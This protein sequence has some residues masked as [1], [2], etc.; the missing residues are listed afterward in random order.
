MRFSDS[1]LCM[2]LLALAPVQAALLSGGG[3]FSPLGEAQECLL[4]PSE[5]CPYPD[6]GPSGLEQA[7][8]GN[9]YSEL[10]LS[11]RQG[12][13]WEWPGGE[14]RTGRADMDFR[15]LVSAPLRSAAGL[16]LYS[17]WPA[18]EWTRGPDS[19]RMY[20][21]QPST[22][23]SV[24]LDWDLLSMHRESSQQ[25][26]LQAEL[27]IAYGPGLWRVGAEYLP[28]SNWRLRG[29]YAQ[30]SPREE[31][32]HW[33]GEETL[34]EGG[35]ADIEALTTQCR[36]RDCSHQ[37]EPGCAVRAAIERGEID[38]SRLLNYLKL[39]EEVAA[40]AAKLAHALKGRTGML[41]MAELYSIAMSLETC[42][43]NSEP[44]AF[45]LDELDR[46]TADMCTDII[47]ALG[48][49]DD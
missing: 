2:A 4:D 15:L 24:L 48:S 12:E 34:A 25:L 39:R 40:A 28:M 1:L 13:S 44:S 27:P 42:L 30:V 37:H 19:A 17:P 16:A 3:W 6:M 29:G 36:F 43:V 41:G 35:F 10:K 32:A 46:A 14:A 9:G 22:Y 21:I 45:W 23:A 26:L 20:Q 49:P 7:L 5:P 33:T 47:A 18:L 38:E 31:I 8:R 11:Q